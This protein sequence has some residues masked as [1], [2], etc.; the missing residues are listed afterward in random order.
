MNHR[1]VSGGKGS[2]AS[3]C[4]AKRPPAST[5]H[6]PPSHTQAA[7]PGRFLLRFLQNPPRYLLAWLAFV[8]CVAF[9]YRDYL[10]R[11]AFVWE[12][13]LY[14]YYPMLNY[15][16]TSFAEGHFPF[17]HTGLRWGM[18][19]YTDL[20]TSVFYPLA[21]LLTPFA[22]VVWHR[23]RAQARAGSFESRF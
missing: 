10:R 18:A 20:Q 14:F 22:F 21:W 8:A 13:M 1:S 19:L 3:R 7:S 17:W 6:S 2:S 16:C 11:A 12:D 23:R 5:P 4:N 9:F 15:V